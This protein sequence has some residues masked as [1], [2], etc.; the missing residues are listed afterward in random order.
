[1]SYPDRR[2]PGLTLEQ[3][4][5]WFVPIPSGGDCLLWPGATSSGGYGQFGWEGR[6]LYAHVTAYTLVHGPVPPGMEVDHIKCVSRACIHQDHLRL[7]TR[8]QNGQNRQALP[9]NNTSGLQGVSWHKASG[10]WTARVQDAGRV[11]AAYFHDKDDAA[12]WVLAKRLELFTHNEIDRV[13]A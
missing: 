11:H 12:D 9:G 13:S 6:T 4:F 1:M 5:A 7:A 10:M 8:K 3:A 2:P